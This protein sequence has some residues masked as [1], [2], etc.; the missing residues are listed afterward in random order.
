MYIEQMRQ[1]VLPYY[2]VIEKNVN[3][4]CEK[5]QPVIVRLEPYYQEYIVKNVSTNSIST[6]THVYI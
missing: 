3:V 4:V 2:K 5:L 6:T 1:L